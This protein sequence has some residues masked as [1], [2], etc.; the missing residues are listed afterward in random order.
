MLY[1][2]RSLNARQRAAIALLQREY[3]AAWVPVLEALAASG[4]LRPTSRSPGC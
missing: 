2:W 3:E 4:R 1:E